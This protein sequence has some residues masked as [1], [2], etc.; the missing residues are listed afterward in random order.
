V[1]PWSCNEP[2]YHTSV[3]IDTDVEFETVFSATMSFDPY[4]VP[5]A[6]VMCTK[7]GAVYCDVHLFSTNKPSR[8][9][10]HFTYV[11]DGEFFHSSLDHTVPRYLGVVLFYD[12]AVFHL[13]FNAI[14]CLVESCF[15]DA[16]YCD[17]F[18]IMSFSSLLF[19]FPWWWYLLYCF[20]YCF[21]EFG[22]EVAVY[23]VCNC[24]VYPF[25]GTSHLIEKMNCFFFNYLFRDEAMF[26][27]I[28]L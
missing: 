26:F 8:S 23:M 21:G 20:D 22:G 15:E 6:A 4:V 25:L 24:W 13:C 10:H 3:D 19:G 7:S 17:I 12:I 27:N 5:G 1:I 28:F 2:V 11:G 14:V 16:S 9:V 18:W